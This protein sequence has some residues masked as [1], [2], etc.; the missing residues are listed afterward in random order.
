M[1]KPSKWYPL[2]PALLLTALLSGCAVD[3][4]SPQQDRPEPPEP[5]FREPS[6][7]DPFAAIDAAFE[8]L[9]LDRY[10]A[11]QNAEAPVSRIWPRL[12]ERFRI[13]D[14][15]ADSSSADWAD[16]YAS[17]PEYM[18]RVLSRARPWLHHIVNEIEARDLPGE[19]ALLPVVESAFDPFAYSHGRAAGPWQFLSGTARDFGLSIDDWYDGRRDVLAATTAALDY[20]EYLNGLFDGDWS[21]ALAAYNAGQ[22]RVRRAM[23]RNA[24][25]GRGLEWH[26]L[27]LPRETL[28][29]VPKL[30]GLGCLF[31]DTERYAFELPEFKDRPR[32][33][34]IRLAGQ[35]DLVALALSAELDLAE[36]VGLNPGLNRH[37][38]PPGNGYRLI[39]PVEL[40]ER[41]RAALADLP[42]RRSAAG[43]QSITVKPGDSLSRLARHHGVT[44]AALRQANRL[45]GDR[46]IAGQSLNLPGLVDLEAVGGDADY[47]AAYRQLIALQQQLLP[48]DRFVHRVGSGESLWLIARRYGVGVGE[49]QRMNG[50][51]AS[52]LIR[53]GRRL[54]IETGRKV[55]PPIRSTERYVVRSGDSLWTIS[56]RQRVGL[57]EL[58]RLNGLDRDSVLR[59]GQRLLIRSGEDA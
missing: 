48:T 31:R 43:W 13:A 23:R 5:S 20:L 15:P 11:P 53:P 55:E 16:W 47:Q 40:A 34:T 52:T 21:L 7:S 2:L 42:E 9:S 58:M 14:C 33:E 54:V 27:R 30:I 1:I 37:M 59:P 6:P 36:L 45:D 41:T 3:P 12:I 18:Q 26:Q 29:Y 24:A 10:R 44:I 51:G 32:I 22:G 46:V 56:R 28:G 50:M 57:Q 38:T 49:I 8:R 39:V 19:L 4:H 35:V 17:N 25:L